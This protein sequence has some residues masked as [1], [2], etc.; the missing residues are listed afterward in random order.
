MDKVEGN[1]EGTEEVDKLILVIR[2]TQLKL[3]LLALGRL[4][5]DQSPAETI[6][7]AEANRGLSN[8][9]RQWFTVWV[10]GMGNF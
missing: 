3:D 6:E 8:G 5:E 1:W 7:G 4:T 9:R 2:V 10:G